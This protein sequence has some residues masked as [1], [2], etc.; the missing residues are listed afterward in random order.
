MA[1]SV[2]AF[3]RHA[4]V[5]RRFPGCSPMAEVSQARMDFPSYP[6]DIV[7]PSFI[8]ADT[9]HDKLLGAVGL[10]AASEAFLTSD[11]RARPETPRT[12]RVDAF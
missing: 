11:E 7:L 6:V 5:P 4:M 12:T 10:R 1:S 9:A 8:H 3:S 2:W